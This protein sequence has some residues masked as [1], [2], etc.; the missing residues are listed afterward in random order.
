MTEARVQ[1][2]YFIGPVVPLGK[3]EP[4]AELSDLSKV[5]CCHLVGFPSSGLPLFSSWYGGVT[6]S[7]VS[8]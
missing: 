8:L 5:T 6:S 2:G 4:R 7:A 1:L 3:L